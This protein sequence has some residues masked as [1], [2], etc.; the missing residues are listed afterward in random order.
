MVTEQRMPFPWTF[1]VGTIL[2]A[3]L[4]AVWCALM[5]PEWMSQP[6]LTHGLFMPVV[7]AALLYEGAKSRSPHYLPDNAGM[8]I[9]QGAVAVFAVLAAAAGGFYGDTMGWDHALAQFF[10]GTAMAA[11][12]LVL[13]MAMGRNGARALPFGWPC[14]AAVLL[15]VLC[16]PVP[17]GTSARLTAA[18]QLG[19]T[20]SVL[21]ILNAVGVPAFRTGNVIELAHARVGVEEACSGLRSLVSCVFAGIFI[22]AAW[23]RR[24]AARVLIVLIAAPLALA[25]NLLRSLGLAYAAGRG[26]RIDGLLHDVAGIAILVATS[27]ILVFMGAVL[28][29]SQGEPAPR[30]Q[31]PS[32]RFRRAPGWIALCALVAAT[33]LTVSWAMRPLEFASPKGALPNLA[34]I[35]PDRVEGW[36]VSAPEDLRIYAPELR[37]G[38]LMQRTYTRLRPWGREEVTLYVAYWRPGQASVSL[39]SSHTPDMCWPGQGWDMVPEVTGTEALRVGHRA[40]PPSQARAFV[41]PEEKLYVWYWHLYGGLP[42]EDFDTHSPRRLLAEVVANGIRANRNQIFVRISANAGWSQVA[43]GPLLATFFSGLRRWGF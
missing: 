3:V 23:M 22:S 19:V 12:I 34:S 5:W 17:P 8:D 14:A 29:G 39:V 24:T 4:F 27:A 16:A 31:V 26:L 1:R 21:R 32:G 35:L 37:T 42:V 20:E 33:A 7:L 38:C 30:A 9:L 13:L 15:C 11:L 28:G 40:L 6:N 2:V 36:E 43:D 25:M 10:L 18:L 41:R